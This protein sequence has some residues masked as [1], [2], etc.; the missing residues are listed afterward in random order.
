MGSTASS[1]KDREIPHLMDAGAA[2]QF[3]HLKTL[4]ADFTVQVGTG[5]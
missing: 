2:M 3:P 4:S 1:Q 5:E